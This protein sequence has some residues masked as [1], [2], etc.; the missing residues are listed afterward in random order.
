MKFQTQKIVFTE[1][2]LAEFQ[3]EEI[4]L[5]ITSPDEVLIKNHYSHVS[6][7]TEL[8]C[9]DGLEDWFPLPGIPGYTAVGEI[10]DK[11][12]SVEQLE[13]GDIVY[14]FG[15]HAKYYLRNTKCRWS[16]ICIK[17]PENLHEDVAAFS[18]MAAI[19][20]TSIRKSNIELGDHVL[21]LGLGTI[22]NLAAQLAQ[23]QGAHVIAFDVEDN[24]VEMA[25]KSNIANAFN[26]KKVEITDLV[27][28]LT[29]GE[30]IATIIDA[31]GMPGA[32]ENVMETL[33]E[34]SEVI[35]LG[36]PRTPYQ[37]NLAGFMK[38]F[39]Y[40]PTNAQLKGALEFTF[41]TFNDGFSK[42]SLERNSKII[43]D[44]LQKK[45][46]VVEPFYSHKVKPQEAP[47]VYNT[48]KANKDKFIGVII[49]W[50]EQNN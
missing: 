15:S 44:L 25:K 16:G 18:H 23:L 1:K 32:I 38:P 5:Q 21:V 34:N 22:G 13:I 33:G 3:E 9:L 31:T 2:H 11:G 29:K 4:D 30:G 49:D 50:T 41:P 47:E 6:M 7:G 14:T 46:L 45:K 43:L 8:A 17:V 40:L 24:R 19:A 10:I 36:S 28:S 35:L 39:H 42:H 37:S 27:K 48:M 12:S 20:F 26:S